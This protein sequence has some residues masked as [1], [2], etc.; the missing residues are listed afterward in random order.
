MIKKRIAKIPLYLSLIAILLAFITYS[1]GYRLF[2]SQLIT[3][4]DRSIHFSPTIIV[5]QK[6]I[7]NSATVISQHDDWLICRIVKKTGGIL[8]HDDNVSLKPVDLNDQLG[9]MSYSQIVA[10][11][12]DACNGLSD[13]TLV[14][15][16]VYRNLDRNKAIVLEQG[17]LQGLTFT[18]LERQTSIRN[19]QILID[20]LFGNDQIQIHFYTTKY[21]DP[22]AV[23]IAWLDTVD[24]ES[25]TKTV[26]ILTSNKLEG[27]T[28]SSRLVTSII[29][30]INT[31]SSWKEE[32]STYIIESQNK[33]ISFNI[34]E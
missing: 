33:T 7:G 13:Q 20:Q 16:Q 18:E 17:A 25:L 21:G 34:K 32:D 9:E 15:D 14:L 1:N 2:L 26:K 6:Q 22:V 8:W 11:Y 28:F 31:D 30:K 12:A 29:D 27:W 3:D 5:Y 4:L 19:D 23:D 10:Q 24:I